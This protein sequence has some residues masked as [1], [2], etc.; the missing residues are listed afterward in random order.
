MRHILSNGTLLASLQ[1]EWQTSSPE[2]NETFEFAWDPL[3]AKK[4]SISALQSYSSGNRPIG[5]GTVDL[6]MLSLDVPVEQWVALEGG[7]GEVLLK[8]LYDDPAAPAAR[9]PVVTFDDIPMAP[10]LPSFGYE[11]HS[12]PRTKAYKAVEVQTCSALWPLHCPL[13]PLLPLA[14]I[15]Y[16]HLKPRYA[17]Y[18]A[19]AP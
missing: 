6:R 4:L 16:S 7:Q 10:M 11:P 9:S 15:L 17:P 2:W 5:H 1:V 14:T 19:C 3:D 8:V 12:P 13:D 18:I